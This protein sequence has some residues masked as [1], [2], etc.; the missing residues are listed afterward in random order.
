MKTF[1]I[2]IG[3]IAL[4]AWTVFVREYNWRAGYAAAIEESESARYFV[5]GKMRELGF[6]KWLEISRFDE[7]CSKEG[8]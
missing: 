1:T 4:F 8:R 6:C 3:V 2:G 7:E 5:S